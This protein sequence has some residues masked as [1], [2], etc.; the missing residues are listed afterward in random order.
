MIGAIL[1]FLGGG[2]IQ[3]L[4][5]K[6]ARAYEMKLAA[7]NSVDRASAELD[8]RRLQNAIEIA[9]VANTD[10]WSATSLGRYFIVIP[11]GV[12]YSAIML[13]STFAFSWDV[14][15]LPD[16]IMALSEWLFPVIVVGD[17]GKYIFRRRG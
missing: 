1:Q 17:V 5:G 16:R 13:D 14:L 10:R 12:W 9:K 8:I 4:T 15:A 2:I 7:E 6:L 11:F 3:D